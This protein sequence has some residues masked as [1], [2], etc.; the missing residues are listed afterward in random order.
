MRIGISGAQSVGKTTLINSLKNIITDIE[1]KG[2]ITRTIQSLGFNINEAG[3]DSTQ[4]EIMKYHLKYLEADNCVYDRTV[5]DGL[6][7]TEFLYNHNQVH[8]STFLSAYTDYMNN[9]NK[10]DILFYI[11]PE[12]DIEDDCQRSTNIEFRNEIVKLFNYYIEKDN[13]PVI[14]LSG[15]VEARTADVINTINKFKGNK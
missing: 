7:Y 6:V 5:L 10:Y 11:K 4:L 1:F 15:D 9:I 3:T 14:I 8:K 13:I 2:E 12:F